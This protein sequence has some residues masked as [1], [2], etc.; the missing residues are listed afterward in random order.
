MHFEDPQSSEPEKGVMCYLLI[1]SEMPPGVA[2][3]QGDLKLL[4][5]TIWF[6]FPIDSC[7]QTCFL[8][9]HLGC[10]TP[11]SLPLAD[12]TKLLIRAGREQMWPG[13]GARNVS[14]HSLT[15]STALRL[16]VG[17]GIF[18]PCSLWEVVLRPC[19]CPTLASWYSGQPG[20]WSA[21]LPVLQRKLEQAS[22][23]RAH[24]SFNQVYE[25]TITKVM[26]VCR[27]PPGKRSK[28]TNK[29]KITCYLAIEG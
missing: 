15:Q 8:Q 3:S 14:R 1:C 12:A 23:T 19:P 9:Q 7:R 24:A 6:H 21:A 27:R 22:S 13:L 4:S 2:L 10:V 11:A 20:D 25:F 16:R 18:T 29:K 5:Q 28:S 17:L 26:Q